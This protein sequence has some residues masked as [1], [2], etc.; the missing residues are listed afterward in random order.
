MGFS[1]PL[2]HKSIFTGFPMFEKRYFL[3]LKPSALRAE[4]TALAQQKRQGFLLLFYHTPNHAA[5][6][7]CLRS[8]SSSFSCARRRAVASFAC[9]I[10][11]SW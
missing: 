1:G 10:C 4:V 6:L 5:G 7:G 9:A 3:L 11:R 2:P 8:Y